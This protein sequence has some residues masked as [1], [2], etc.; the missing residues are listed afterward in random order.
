M[1]SSDE[2]RAG[3]DAAQLIPVIRPTARAIII[4]QQ[5]ILLL[6]KHY[7]EFG[8]RFALP[9]GAQEPTESL[10]QA[11]QRECEEE[12]GTRV[13][14]GPLLHVADYF[15]QRETEPPTRRH[16][17]EMLCRCQVPSDY[18]PR[19]GHHPDRHQVAVIWAD[20]AAIPGMPL[21]PPYLATCL[22]HL[23]M[24]DRPLYLGKVES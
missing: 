12:I 19:N 13:E 16:L 7:A 4:R 22:A 15:K 20:L 8:E 23:D 21:F 3:E 5:R 17:L 2:I 6:R 24:P 18:V 11:L 9:G 10:H 1:S 14:I